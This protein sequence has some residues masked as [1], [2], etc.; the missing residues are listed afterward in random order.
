[1]ALRR[2]LAD[3]LAQLKRFGDAAEQYDIMIKDYPGQSMLHSRRGMLLMQMERFIDAR[4][5]FEEA[6]RIDQ[7]NMEA[8]QHLQMLI[9]LGH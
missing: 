3:A 9:N 1:M 8:R 5:D 2:N 4:A 7:N 6:L